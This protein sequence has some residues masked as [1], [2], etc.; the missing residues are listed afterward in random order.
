MYEFTT[1]QMRMK[2]FYLPKKI[3]FLFI[4]HYDENVRK[5]QIFQNFPNLFGK[6]WCAKEI[7]N[8]LY[9]GVL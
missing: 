7:L 1:H 4:L 3:Y 9:A 8:I 6:F 2:H 5:I